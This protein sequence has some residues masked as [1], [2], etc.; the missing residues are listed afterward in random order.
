MTLRQH[1]YL[2]VLHLGRWALHHHLLRWSHLLH[3]IEP[4]L[5]VLPGA[6]AQLERCQE[7]VIDIN[8]FMNKEMP[9][10]TWEAESRIGLH[11]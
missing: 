9:R 7:N 4:A 5:W 2:V 6:S 1:S 8:T 11:D 10:M 3:V